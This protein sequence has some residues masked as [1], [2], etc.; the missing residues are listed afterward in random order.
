MCLCHSKK[1]YD[2]CCKRYHDG[3]LPE[4]ALTLMR[5]RYSAYAL[6]LAD[7]VMQTTHQA[8]HSADWR[9]S[10]LE[11][12][13]KTQFESLAILDFADDRERATVTFR[14]G[15]S[16]SGRDV[17]FTEKSQFIKKGGRWLYVA[18]ESEIVGRR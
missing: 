8:T 4:D 3:A 1:P 12:G 5:S 2:E 17:S 6:S 16:E 11:F 7:Y 14:A 15:L 9:Q 10:I 13:Q 18:A